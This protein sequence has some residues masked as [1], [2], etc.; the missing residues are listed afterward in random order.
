MKN[1]PKYTKNDFLHI[2]ARS[3]PQEINKIIEE[4]G[5]KARYQTFIIWNK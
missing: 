4:R 1:K 2:L 5:K 3:T